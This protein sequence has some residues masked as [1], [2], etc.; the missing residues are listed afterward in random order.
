[1]SD[2]DVRNYTPVVNLV[3]PHFRE[4]GLCSVHYLAAQVSGAVLC[5]RF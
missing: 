4:T 5:F 1:M 3:I 2:G